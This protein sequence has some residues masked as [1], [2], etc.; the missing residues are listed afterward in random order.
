MRPDNS[1]KTPNRQYSPNT[2]KTTWDIGKTMSYAGKIISDIIQTT[3]D[4]I[5]AVCNTLKNKTLQINGNAGQ[6]AEI[7]YVG[8]R[9]RIMQKYLALLKLIGIFAMS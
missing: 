1:G 2:P 8:I 4:I 5:F 3:S 7:Q 9:I 6:K